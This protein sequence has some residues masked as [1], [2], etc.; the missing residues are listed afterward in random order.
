MKIVLMD[1]NSKLKLSEAE[2]KNSYS[3]RKTLNDFYPK[4]NSDKNIKFNFNNLK[5]ISK[6]FEN[7]YQKEI[8][9]KKKKI[10]PFKSPENNKY[11]YDFTDSNLIFNDNNK[12]LRSFNININNQST[13]I[14]K[15]RKRNIIPI[16][17]N[18][19]LSLNKN[20]NKMMKLKLYIK[21]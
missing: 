12:I 2:N 11:N 8:K 6:Y 18:Y 13:S 16:T 3:K 4:L 5:T 15:R 9:N 19:K 14:E 1:D 21:K 10:N 17:T 7:E 20:R